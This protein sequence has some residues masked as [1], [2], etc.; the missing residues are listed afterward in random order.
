VF[1]VLQDICDFVLPVAEDDIVETWEDV[2]G[3]TDEIIEAAP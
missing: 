1:H 2:G 3:A